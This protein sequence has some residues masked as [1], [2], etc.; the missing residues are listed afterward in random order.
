[1]ERLRITGLIRGLGCTIDADQDG[2]MEIR[3]ARR[4][5]VWSGGVTACRKVDYTGV[6]GRAISWPTVAFKAARKIFLPKRCSFSPPFSVPLIE[7]RSS[8][9]IALSA[10]NLSGDAFR[11]MATERRSALEAL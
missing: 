1:M 4:P 6:L 2:K 5:E 3:V 9:T 11:G 7:A 10:A 8:R